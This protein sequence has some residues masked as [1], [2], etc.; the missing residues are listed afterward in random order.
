MGH[1]QKSRIQ[2]TVGFFAIV[3][4]VLALSWLSWEAGSPRLAEIR[5]HALN[6]RAQG[7]RLLAPKGAPKTRF[8]VP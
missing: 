6:A 1:S 3:L 5:A 4:A 8:A 2:R 7:L